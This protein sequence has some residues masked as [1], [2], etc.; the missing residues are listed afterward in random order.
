MSKLLENVVRRFI[1][2]D[3]LR[4]TA[5]S[6]KKEVLNMSTKSFKLGLCTAIAG[7]I[8]ANASSLF[9]W[10][11]RVS[12]PSSATVAGIMEMSLAARTIDTDTN[13]SNDLTAT[14]VDFGSVGQTSYALAPQYLV[15]NATSNVVGGNK[16]WWIEIYTDNVSAT[17]VPRVS[18]TTVYGPRASS[19]TYECAGLVS[20]NTHATN[21]ALGGP[22]TTNFFR[23]P[24]TWI[25]T[26]GSS[27][28]LNGVNAQRPIPTTGY[29]DDIKS[30]IHG[31]TIA[32]N[33]GWTYVKD[34]A[35]QDDYSMDPSTGPK[36]WNACHNSGYT[37]VVWGQPG[38]ARKLAYMLD[39]KTPVYVHLEGDLTTACGGKDYATRIWFDLYH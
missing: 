22:G 3:V 17:A 8:L 39:T 5:K 19:N 24:L 30:L 27:G 11:K 7:F 29:G 4:A 16:A 12:M 18:T 2:A 34:K 6:N 38:N 10:D 14:V 32:M 21:P 31:T 20:T 28:T 9:A 13:D 15:L 23:I 35:D 25:V 26:Q 33:V 36:S 37:T 1:V